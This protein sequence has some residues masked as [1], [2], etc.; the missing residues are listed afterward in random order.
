MRNHSFSTE[1]SGSG[2]A[3]REWGV[4]I[5][6][7]VPEPWGCGTEGRGQWAWG[8]GLGLDLVILEAFSSLNDSMIHK[9]KRTRNSTPGAQAPSWLVKAGNETTFFSIKHVETVPISAQGTAGARLC[10]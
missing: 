8:G 7:G 5:P 9:K 10:C 3:A 1:Q 4:T 6:G 2:T